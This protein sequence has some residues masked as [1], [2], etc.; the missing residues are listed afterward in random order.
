MSDYAR[1]TLNVDVETTQIFVDRKAQ[2]IILPMHGFAVPF[3]IDTIKNASKNDEGDYTYLRI[4]FQTSGQL[5]GKKDE[6]VNARP[7]S[8]Y[9]VA[10]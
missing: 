4:N 6:T 1:C 2:T 5:T 3:H 8:S 10:C 7:V 9:V